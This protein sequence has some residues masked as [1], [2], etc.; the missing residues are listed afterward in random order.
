MLTLMPFWKA[1]RRRK[2]FIFRVLTVIDYTPEPRDQQ[3]WP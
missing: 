3:P 2:W 1:A